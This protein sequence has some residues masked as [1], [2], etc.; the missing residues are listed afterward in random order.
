MILFLITLLTG[1]M[2]SAISAYY[3]ILGLM[4]IFAAAPIP[5][6]IMGGALEVSKLIA[7]VWL[8]QNWNHAP[9]AIRWYLITSVIILM[10]ITS[11]GCFG[12]LSKAHLD[13]TIPT[14]DVV[15]KIEIIDD[16]IKTLKDNVDT[17]KGAVKQL[18][19]QVDQ[20]LGRSTDERGATKAVT[21][22]RQQAKERETLQADIARYQTEIA[23]LQDERSPIAKELRKVEAEVGPIKYIAKFVYSADDQNFLEK[24]VTWLIILLIVVFDPLAIVLLLASQYSFQYRKTYVEPIEKIIETV[25][26]ATT[27]T[28]T[29]TVVPPDESPAAPAQIVVGPGFV[30]NSYVQNE[31]QAQSRLWTSTTEKIISSDDYKKIAQEKRQREIDKYI[32]LVR[33]QS[34]RMT[35][36]PED[37]Q[38][39]VRSR[40]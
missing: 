25:N 8:K 17:A 28:T 33:S 39:T 37:L 36:V 7:T 13:Q 10:L 4:A 9:F 6:M 24:S 30:N 3:S 11:I 27:V 14:G 35:D 40:V 15:A 20:I 22:R 34:I 32:D 18:D 16:K 26:T 21:I 19:S 23:R 12:F 5:I 2:L 1:L 38:P 29:A 31:E